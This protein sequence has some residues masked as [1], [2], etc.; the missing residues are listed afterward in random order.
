VQVTLSS[1]SE[2]QNIQGTTAD[3]SLGNRMRGR[4]TWV[5][6]PRST[7]IALAQQPSPAPSPLWR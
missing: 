6:S 3:A 4:L 5:G 1:R 2:A 7:L